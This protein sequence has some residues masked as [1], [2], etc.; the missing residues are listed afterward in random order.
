MFLTIK[1]KPVYTSE[2][3]HTSSGARIA[4]GGGTELDKNQGKERKATNAGGNPLKRKKAENDLHQ[5]SS[6]SSSYSKTHDH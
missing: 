3:K 2:N 5:I 1:T 6:H 4:I